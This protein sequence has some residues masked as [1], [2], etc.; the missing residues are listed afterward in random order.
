[1]K[2]AR[3]SLPLTKVMKIARPTSPLL[4]VHRLSSPRPRLRHGRRLALFSR[5]N[6]TLNLCALFFALFVDLLPHLPP[7][8]TSSIVPF[9]GNRLRSS[10]ISRDPTLVSLSQMPF[11]AEPEATFPSSAQSN[12]QRRL[13]CPST[14]PFPLLNFLRLP[15][16]SPRP[17]PLAQTKL[18]IPC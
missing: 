6:L 16:N 3:F 14:H 18:P 12:A 7:L 1:M 2:D 17:L 13:T 5:P 15:P 11:V 9:L 8:L 4:D 10:S